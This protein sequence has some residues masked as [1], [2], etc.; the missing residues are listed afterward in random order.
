MLKIVVVSFEL[1]VAGREMKV[2]T[3][4]SFL[5]VGVILLLIMD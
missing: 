4:Q 1:F 3:S 2:M 5:W